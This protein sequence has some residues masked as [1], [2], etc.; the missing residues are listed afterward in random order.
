MDGA[1]RFGVEEEYFLADATTGASPDSAAADRFHK[2]AASV[3]KPASHE[4]LKGQIEVQTEPGVNFD[5]ARDQLREMRRDLAKVAAEHGLLVFAAGSHPLA[6]SREQDTTEKARYRRLEA[7]LGLIASR[8]MICATH[9]H[10]EA[11]EADGRIGVMNRLLPFLPL[12]LALSVSSPFWQGRD[13]RLKGY[14]LTA[15]A[16]WPRTGLPELFRDQHEYQRF[17]DLLVAAGV[18]EDATFV[19]WHIRPSTRFPTI[20]LRVCD[21]CPRL[22]DAIAIAALYQALFRCVLRRP[23]LNADMGPVDRGVCASNIW[24]AQQHGV[25]AELID[26]A[27]AAARPVA[28]HLDVALELVEQDAEA[29]G[30]SEWVGRTRDILKRGTSA[31]R[32]LAAYRNAKAEG[33]ADDD[34]LREVVRSLAEETAS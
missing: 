5:A 16:E 31:D 9:I 17:I 1:F 3:V 15:F 19:W 12:L 7:E 22:D 18:V 6:K 29:L 23:E 34:A 2:A 33:A 30:S 4:L 11:P 21:S 28:A 25:E 20:E 27:L 14:R 13:T 8:T 10:V 24:Q 26:V 32:Q